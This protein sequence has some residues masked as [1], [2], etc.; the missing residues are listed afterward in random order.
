MLNDDLL[1]NIPE[2]NLYPLQHVKTCYARYIKTG[3]RYKQK[4]AEEH[5]SVQNT[6]CSSYVE[7]YSPEIGPKRRKTIENV[8]TREQPC[9]IY[10]CINHKGVV[11]RYC[12]SEKPR[13]VNFI[14][15]YNFS[16]DDVH[17]GCILYKTPGD[18]F[19]ADIMY[20]KTWLDLYF[21]KF[22]KDIENILRRR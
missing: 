7:V 17:T 9:I 5:R 10:N 8:G 11:S 12:I 14:R 1:I 21:Y 20:H 6:S 19:A 4:Q 16:K 3:E 2:S 13:A 22:R 18:I 15:A